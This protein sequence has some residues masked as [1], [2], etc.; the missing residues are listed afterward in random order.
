LGV[1]FNSLRGNS[2]EIIKNQRIAAN[3]PGSACAK[4][5]LS[6]NTEFTE[7]VICT[8]SKKYQT[9]KLNELK[10]EELSSSEFAEKSKKITDK[11]C[12]CEGLANAALINYDI[13]RKGEKQGV[14]ICPGPNMAY[15]S[16]DLSLKEMVN[17]IYGR[18][19]VI[20]T[21]NRPHIFLK[22]L[23]LYVDY[24][25]NKVDEINDSFNVKQQKYLT[26]FQNNLN[27]GIEYYQK[28]FSETK[29]YFESNKE[30]LL[31]ELG[32]LQNELFK[33]KIP[34]LIKA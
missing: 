9:I 10:L 28:L 20:E 14:A 11:A 12:L 33:I 15:F 26:S 31:K 17:H 19:N 2:N 24:F 5:F 30:A 13:E 32:T 27:D 29:I 1:P 25:S 23:A 34:I 18:T 6:S 16:K 4:K 8:A 21:K 7:K 22:E 3:K